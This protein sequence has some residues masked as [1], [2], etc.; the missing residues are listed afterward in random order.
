MVN[1]LECDIIV[2]ESDLHLLNYVHNW[3][4][5]LAKSMNSLCRSAMGDIVQ[6]LFY[7]MDYF[8]IK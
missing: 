2:S 5:T 3:T 4:N 1:A 6:L 8:E 7:Y